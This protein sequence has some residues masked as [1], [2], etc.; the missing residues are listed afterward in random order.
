MPHR[1]ARAYT[2]RSRHHIHP[3]GATFSITTLVHDAVPQPQLLKLSLRRQ[4]ELRKIDRSDHPRKALHRY[5]VNTLFSQELKRLLSRQS[6]Q[7]HPFRQ[8]L[9]AEI[10]AEQIKKYAGKYYRL[11]AFSIMSNHV[12]LL[13]DFS[14]QLAGK[15]TANA[16]PPGYVNLERVMNYIKGGSAYSINRRCNRQGPLWAAGYYDRYIRSQ[17]HYQQALKYILNN[18]VKA[19]LVSRWEDHPFT[20]CFCC[21]DL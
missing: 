4:A 21:G 16:A 11:C 6:E 18:P 19:G 20:D 5:L 14:I 10:L 13:L 3:Y 1:N 12:H 15:S 7:E 9:A 17:R 8:S 2:R